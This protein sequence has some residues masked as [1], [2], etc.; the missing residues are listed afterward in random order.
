MRIDHLEQIRITTLAMLKDSDASVVLFGSRARGMHHPGSDVDIGII[1]RKP[2]DK[3][4][5]SLLRLTF[6]ESSIPYKIDIVDL[7][8]TSPEFRSVALKDS[9]VWKN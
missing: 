1:P 5:L 7:S 6:E 2:I 3:K 4:I 9:V 8:E